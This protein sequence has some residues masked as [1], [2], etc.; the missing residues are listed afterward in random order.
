MDV[1]S[2][3]VVIPTPRPQCPN[4]IHTFRD[5]EVDVKSGMRRWVCTFCAQ[6]EHG[7][8]PRVDWR[9]PQRLLPHVEEVAEVVV[10]SDD[11]VSIN[12]ANVS[13]AGV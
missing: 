12:G 5:L 9:C 4:G 2:E 6:S 7:D 10:V 11:D 1:A 8:V 3:L 13:D